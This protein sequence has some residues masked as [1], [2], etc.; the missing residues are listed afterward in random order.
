MIVCTEGYNLSS[1]AAKVVKSLNIMKLFL[2]F[3]KT[4]EFF[5]FSLNTFREPTP[6]AYPHPLP[7]RRGEG[8]YP[9]PLPERRGDL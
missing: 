5:Q 3:F 1:H 9:H 7:E 4:T 2:F 8:A 6:R